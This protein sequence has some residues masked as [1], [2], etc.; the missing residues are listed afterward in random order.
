MFPCIVCTLEVSYTDQAVDCDRCN[1]WCHISCGTNI[2][3]ERYSEMRTGASIQW[4]CGPCRDAENQHGSNFYGPFDQE[5]NISTPEIGLLIERRL[6]QENILITY[7][8][9]QEG[10]Q[11]GG[12]SIILHM[13]YMIFILY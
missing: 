3:H 4:I 6:P 10:G 2:T 1:R 8:V 13:I 11:K 12:V 9:V 7:E 5:G